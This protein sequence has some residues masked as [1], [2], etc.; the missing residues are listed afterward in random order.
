MEQ[1][2]PEPKQHGQ[3]KRKTRT[4][5]NAKNLQDKRQQCYKALSP[6]QEQGKPEPKQNQLVGNRKARPGTRLKPTQTNTTL[7]VPTY[8]RHQPHET[9][10]AYSAGTAQE[11]TKSLKPLFSTICGADG[12]CPS[13]GLNYNSTRSPA[14]QPQHGPTLT[15]SVTKEQNLLANRP[16][17]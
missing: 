6:G 8:T 14:L 17:M 15:I 2:K 12:G 11:S 5:S 7:P 9:R 3:H 10:N 4:G 1:G 16:S 13:S